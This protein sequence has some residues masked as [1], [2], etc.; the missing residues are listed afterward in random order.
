M[1]IKR[2]MKRK[3][4]MGF[5]KTDQHPE[6]KLRSDDEGEIKFG[7]THLDGEVVLDFGTSVTWVG[8]PPSLA[9]QLAINLNKHADEIE[10]NV[11]EEAH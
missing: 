8:M 10:Q 11:N 2:K 1:S 5:G 4:P 9:R 7:V 6:G 3:H